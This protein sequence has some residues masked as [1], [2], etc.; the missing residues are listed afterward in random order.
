MKLLK[1][2]L[3]KSYSWGGIPTDM[4]VSVLPA[5]FSIFTLRENESTETLQP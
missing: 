5:R 3:P 4:E 1:T 2:F